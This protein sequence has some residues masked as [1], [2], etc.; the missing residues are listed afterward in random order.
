MT[1]GKSVTPNRRPRILFAWELGENFGHASKITEIVR[2]M[3]GRAKVTVA[4]QRPEAISV[5]AGG[6]DM[7]VGPAP[8]VPYRPPSGP[9]DMALA[10]SDNLAHL[11]WDN[12]GQLLR[13]VEDWCAVFAREAPDLLVTQA[14]P[15]AL[16]AAR[17]AGGLATA[18]F[19]SGFDIPPRTSPM[20]R[21]F[22][23]MKDPDGT[24]ARRIADREKAVLATINTV[25]AAGNHAPLA[26]FA[27]V[28]RADR[29]YLATVPEIDQYAPRA[30]FEPDHPAYCGQL[31]TTTEGATCDWRRG[32]GGKRI[33]AYL[34][35][36]RPETLPTLQA[37]ATLAP[38]HDIILTAPGIAPE[39]ARQ[40]TDTGVWVSE[41]PLRLDHLLPETEIGIGHA[42]NGTS[43][44][45]LMSGLPQLC[46]PTQ[47]E[48]TMVA[49]TL[50][51]NKLGLALVGGFSA[52]HVMEH[53]ARLIADKQ[54]TANCRATAD[55]LSNDPAYANP[56]QRIA[57]GLVA[58]AIAVQS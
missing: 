45:F 22:H 50:A 13:L 3:N 6:L 24:G 46:L 19:G 35:V 47:G 37:L 42:S 21:F 12:P 38:K 43:A 30:R 31:F 8:F 2:A 58:Q 44:A 29:T 39:M 28:L 16:L 57:D 51:H 9:D 11:G 27:D 26:V 36:D 20:P 23:W 53:V 41:E 17:F 10:Y 34:R 18:N 55:R 7:R 4:A 48:Q 40:L 5:M 15:T 56:A 25:L 54:I 32:R 52:G 33:L 14:A 49:R 1:A